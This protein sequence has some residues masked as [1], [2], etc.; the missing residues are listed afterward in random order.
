MNNETSKTMTVLSEHIPMTIAE[1]HTLLATEQISPA[2]FWLIALGST[3]GGTG[4]AVPLPRADVQRIIDDIL[5]DREEYD[6]RNM[7]SGGFSGRGGQPL[8]GPEVSS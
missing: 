4:A 2:V 7:P 5:T 3:G 1:I 6:T 8:S